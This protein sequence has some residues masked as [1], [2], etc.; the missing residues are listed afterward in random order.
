M[1]GRIL[2]YW[3]ALR[4]L[5]ATLPEFVWLVATAAGAPRFVTQAAAPVAAKL[6]HTKAHRIATEEEV[7]AYRAIES[8]AVKQA[9]LERKRRAGAAVVV[10]EEPATSEPSPR[11]RR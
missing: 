7:A 11:R 6:L 4:E 5:E 8:A 10:V 9:T 1:N 3:R 2:D